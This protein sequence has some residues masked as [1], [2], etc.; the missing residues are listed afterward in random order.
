M[1]DQEYK[2]GHLA[3]F[4]EIGDNYITEKVSI[5]DLKK[6]DNLER[7]ILGTASV[8]ALLGGLALEPEMIKG[9]TQT[10]A[11]PSFV[12]YAVASF[13]PVI[14]GIYGLMGGK[15][16]LDKYLLPKKEK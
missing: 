11:N 14:S 6:E 12:D 9:V 1:T 8:I 5:Q 2:M 13:S 15:Y 7:V 3:N 4:P 16:V 10:I